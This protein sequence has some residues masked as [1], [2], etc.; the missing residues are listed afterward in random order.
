MKLNPKFVLYELFV[1]L[2]KELRNKDIPWNNL[3]FNNYIIPLNMPKVDIQFFAKEYHS[4]FVDYFYYI[5][6]NYTQCSNCNY[7]YKDEYIGYFI[8]LSGK[9]IEKV[10]T[11]IKEY[12]S[13]TI[14]DYSCKN[15]LRNGKGIERIKFY[16]S[17]QY[18]I[19]DFEG[20]KCNKDLDI[21]FDISEYILTSI[22]PRKYQLYAFIFNE[23]GQYKAYIRTNNLW[24]EYSGEN[25][26][27]G[28]RFQSFNS[29]SPN[30]A[31]Y[32]GI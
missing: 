15:C 30:I 2:R 24:Y 9:K 17:P 14:I 31:I 11:L 32:R 8:P 27:N 20:S 23:N 19:L 26:V 29:F 12:F 7:S 21:E 25:N 6:L 28:I 3:I 4:P 18:L 22:G 16:N 1:N 10:S 5:C 13:E